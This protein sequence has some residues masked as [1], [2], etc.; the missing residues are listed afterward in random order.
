MY[1]IACYQRHSF[2]VI[3]TIAF[4]LVVFIIYTTGIFSSLQSF[5]MYTDT[6]YNICIYTWRV[7]LAKIPLLILVSTYL[8]PSS[9]DR[10]R[11]PRSQVA[12]KLLPLVHPCSLAPS[13]P[14]SQP[15]SGFPEPNVHLIRRITNPFPSIQNRYF[16]DT[17]VSHC[18]LTHLEII[19]SV[20]P[21]RCLWLLL[22][23]SKYLVHISRIRT[24]CLL[25]NTTTEQQNRIKN[26]WN[27]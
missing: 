18:P 14:N 22:Q 13:P 26:N 16:F 23:G 4:T 21:L 12:R 6:S 5:N 15:S 27:E 3:Y 20:Y 11:P 10:N 17:V 24:E 19:G 1:T 2:I 7:S 8:A 9:C 25:N